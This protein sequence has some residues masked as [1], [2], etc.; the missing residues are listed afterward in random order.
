LSEVVAKAFES[1]MTPEQ[2]HHVMKEHFGLLG[3]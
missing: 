2:Y 1:L 3:V